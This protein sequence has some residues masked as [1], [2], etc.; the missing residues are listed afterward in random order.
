MVFGHFIWKSCRYG[1]ESELLVIL[2]AANALCSPLTAEN[3][4]LFSSVHLTPCSV[5]QKRRKG[6]CPLLAVEILIVLF[7]LF[8]YFFLSSSC[9]ISE[10]DATLTT[11]DFRTWGLTGDGWRSIYITLPGASALLP[12]PSPLVLLFN[13]GSAAE[14]ACLERGIMCICVCVVRSLQRSHNK[15]SAFT[16]NIQSTWALYVAR[17]SVCVPHYMY[18]SK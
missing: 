9:E 6:R 7:H 1:C 14:R 13:L 4:V 11:E 2:S 16:C 15:G 10:A 12:A 5:N 3:T 8:I 17:K 18:A